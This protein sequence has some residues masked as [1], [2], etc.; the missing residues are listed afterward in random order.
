MSSA[1]VTV[2]PK[3]RAPRSA[4]RRRKDKEAAKLAAAATTTTDEATPSNDAAAGQTSQSPASS[5]PTPGSSAVTSPPSNPTP[6]VAKP[7][8][9][10]DKKKAARQT[11]HPPSKPTPAAAPKPKPKPAAVP[12]ATSSGRGLSSGRG[13]SA[14]RTAHKYDPSSVVAKKAER[15]DISSK[16]QFPSLG[17]KSTKKGFRVNKKKAVA[18]DP[19]E[20]NMERGPPPPR[21]ESRDERPVYGQDRRPA[22]NSQSGPVPGGLSSR[23]KGY[24]ARNAANPDGVLM[25]LCSMI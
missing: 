1:F 9:I 20:V 3:T 14:R 15:P 7:A 13:F 23:S 24:R 5:T 16:E 21:D 18:Y 6:E 25:V 4:R 8:S 10:W 19:T 22:Y 12:S 11:A 2:A 17:G